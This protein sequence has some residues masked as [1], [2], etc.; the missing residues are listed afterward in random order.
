MPSGLTSVNS[1][2]HPEIT[3]GDYKIERFL[4]AAGAATGRASVL[5]QRLL[6]FAR[7]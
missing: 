4:D 1:A 3:R 7:Q 6:A 2:L 5:T